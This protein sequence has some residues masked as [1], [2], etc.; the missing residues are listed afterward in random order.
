MKSLLNKPLPKIP[1][2]IVKELE[3]P[4]ITPTSFDDKDSILYDCS[5]QQEVG[6]TR[7]S[8]GNWLVSMIC[9]MPGITAEMIEW[10]FWWHCQED[11][12][13]QVWFP[14]EHLSTSTSFII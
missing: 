12:R 8:D 2:T 4:R 7:L 13:Y 10:W 11:L 9:P 6:Y 5:L 1:E 14:G 3:I